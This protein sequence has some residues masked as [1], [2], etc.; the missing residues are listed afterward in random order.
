MKRGQALVRLELDLETLETLMVE[1]P[2]VNTV[3][4][5]LLL[6]WSYPSFE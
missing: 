3:G 4:T 2:T 6:L 5:S 1:L